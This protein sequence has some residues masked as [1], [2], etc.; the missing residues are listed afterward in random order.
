MFSTPKKLSFAEIEKFRL[1]IYNRKGKDKMVY[2]Y[3]LD[4]DSVLEGHP[5]L[6]RIRKKFN[7]IHN[8]KERDEAALRFRD[9]VAVKLKQGWNPLIQESGKKGFTLYTIALERYEHYLKKLL[10]DKVLKEKTFVDYNSRLRQLK[11]YN[12]Q[13]Q[14]KMVYIYQFD[15]CYIEGFLEYI[16]IERDT[17]PRTRNNY[18]RW[19][20]SLCTYLYN[21]GYI[22]SNSAERIALL[23]EDDKRRKTLT[24][25]DMQRL[26][27]YLQEHNPEF[28]LACQVHYYTLIRP[29]EM[30]HIV[31]NDIDLREQTIFVS[32]E[33]SKN[34]HDGKV[35]LPTKVIHRMIDQGIFNYPGNYYLF[36]KGFTPTPE[37]ADA[38]IFREEWVKVREALGF[39]DTYQF[40]SLKDTGITDAIDK[41]GLTIIKDQA[42]HSSIEITNKYIRKEQMK[43]H[44]ELKNYEGNL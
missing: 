2:F 40:Y 14:S 10:K 32:K 20:S 16:Y 13:L 33:H 37:R 23:R 44:P 42:R 12:E 4:P 43:A 15:R 17:S 41:V 3:V 6:R 7:H 25:K 38:R 26:S 19:V 36:G 24:A 22:A 11:D 9:E 21:N 34:R 5:R 35:T 39:P 1:P 30:S 31:I 28:L 27:D 29:G 8:K 18:L